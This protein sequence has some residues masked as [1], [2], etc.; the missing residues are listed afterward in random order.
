MR[1]SSGRPP[2]AAAA[3]THGR[4]ETLRLGGGH[5]DRARAPGEQVRGSGVGDEPAVIDHDHPVRDGLSSPRLWLETKTHRPWSA[6]SRTKSRSQMM[7]AGQD[8]GGLV[9]QDHPGIAEHRGRDGQ[10]LA[11]AE[12]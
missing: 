2:L 10:A 1:R 6:R 12:E 4:G 7:P 8:P 11:H 3:Q 9:E 5:H